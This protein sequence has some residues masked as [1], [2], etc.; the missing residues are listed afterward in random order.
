MLQRRGPCRVAAHGPVADFDA[1]VRRALYAN[2]NI[3]KFRSMTALDAVQSEE[4]V[5][6]DFAA[7]WN[8][9]LRCQPG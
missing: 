2:P 6:L 8:S 5:M 7:V 4:R 9:I 1:F 3:H